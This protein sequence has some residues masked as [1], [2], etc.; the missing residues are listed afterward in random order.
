MADKIPLMDWGNPSVRETFAL[1]K[2]KMELYFKI[3]GIDD[4]EPQVPYILRGV[5]DEGLRRYNTWGL[6]DAQK[7]NPQVIWTR[8]EQTLA[9]SEN[10]RISRLKLHHLYM[11]D[12][13]TIDDFVQR[14]KVQAA[15]C[16][17]TPAE[18]KDRILEQIIASTRD[19]E[20]QKE[21]LSKN[22]NYTLEEAVELGRTYEAQAHSLQNLQ[23][24]NISEPKS[25]TVDAVRKSCCKN[26]GRSHPRDKTQCPA[27][28]SICDACGAKGHWKQ[29]CIK[30]KYQRRGRSHSKSRRRYNS[31]SRN[32]NKSPYSKQKGVH[33]V[34][35]PEYDPDNYERLTFETVSNEAKPVRRAAFATLDV[36]LG[37]RGVHGL[38]LKADTGAD[39]N[40]MP[41][42]VFRS[43]FPDRLDA[44]GIPKYHEHRT[45]YAHTMV[46]TS[47]ATGGFIFPASTRTPDGSIPTSML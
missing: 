38:R 2:Q 9:P 26:C 42:R 28:D 1:F 5:D 18:T 3:K 13:E 30:S 12:N 33:S 44:E 14:C 6:T 43:M 35:Q 37:K 29:Y 19:Q 46:Q 20:F 47:S 8:F 15:S 25:A 11:Q 24:L 41:I 34:H 32:R 10:F 31:H 23:K 36:N 7:K 21:L 16:D 45:N 40:L 4:P 17:F 27:Y 39:D 22:K